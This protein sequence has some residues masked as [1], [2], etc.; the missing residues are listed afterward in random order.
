M[1]RETVISESENNL[2]DNIAHAVGVLVRNK[3]TYAMS[4]W[5]SMLRGRRNSEMNGKTGGQKTET[6]HVAEPA[7]EPAAEPAALGGVSAS[8]SSR[9]RAAPKGLDRGARGC[10]RASGLA[11]STGAGGGVSTCCPQ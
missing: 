9:G 10:G 3:A 8:T 11:S 6:A 7:T 2:P 5:K 4:R 1:S